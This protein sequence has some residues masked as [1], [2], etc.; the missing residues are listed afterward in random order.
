[1]VTHASNLN[2]TYGSLTLLFVLTTFHM[3]LNLESRVT[4]GIRVVAII[5]TFV[6]LLLRIK[7]IHYRHSSPHF[8]VINDNMLVK[9][10]VEDT[11]VPHCAIMIKP[12]T[13]RAS[14]CGSKF[15]I[16]VILSYFKISRVGWSFY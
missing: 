6:Y 7:G 13:L 4:S 8:Q 5:I 12:F 15:Q 1:M 10:F 3:S 14:V 16:L 11:N 2:I 9:E